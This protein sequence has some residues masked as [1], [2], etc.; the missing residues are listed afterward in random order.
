[1]IVILKMMALCTASDDNGGDNG[2]P[3]DNYNMI[4]T[5]KLW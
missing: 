3:D 1:M 4:M 5:M 2:E